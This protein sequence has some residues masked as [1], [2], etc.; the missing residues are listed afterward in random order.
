[1]AGDLVDV[2]G[3]KTRECRCDCSSECLETDAYATSYIAFVESCIWAS[4]FLSFIW[5]SLLCRLARSNSKP[6]G[7]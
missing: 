3:A 1:M 4:N 2:I 7:A 6:T 5:R